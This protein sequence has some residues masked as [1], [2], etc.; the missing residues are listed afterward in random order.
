MPSRSTPR[1]TNRKSF[2]YP[3]DVLD[4]VIAAG[5]GLPD[6]DPEVVVLSDIDV[7]GR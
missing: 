2:F 3:D 4:S 7:D 5:R 6:D 1:V